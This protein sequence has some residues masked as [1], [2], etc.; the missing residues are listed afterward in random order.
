MIPTPYIFGT[1]RLGDE[2]IP[3]EVRVDV[4]GRAIDADLWIHTSD[5]YGS[6]LSVLNEALDLDRDR[7]PKMIF[8]IGWE[9]VSQIREQIERQLSAVGM[10]SMAVGQLCLGGALAEAFAVNDP[11]WRELLALRDEGIVDRFVLETWP[12]TSSVPLAAIS[13]GWAGELIDALIFYLNPLQRFLSNE[14]WDVV[15]EKEFPLIGMRTVCGGSIERLADPASTA[16]EYL[17]SRAV[18]VQPLYTNSGCETWTE[19]C[20]RFTH[21][22]PNVL[23]TV[24][25]TSRIE[26][27]NEFIASAQTESALPV[28]VRTA[29]ESLQREWWDDH[30]RFAA[31]WSM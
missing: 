30:D 27:L 18:A 20:F 19:F 15:I 10:A 26:N 28:D 17:K 6:A 8:K 2:S 11:A 16:P 14:L 25:S 23:A 29:V 13:G 21:G 3:R 12:W 31:P 1:T 9:S 7:T 22:Y 4:A 24:G 5:Q